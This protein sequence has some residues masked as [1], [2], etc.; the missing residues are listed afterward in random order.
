MPLTGP[1]IQAAIQ[2]AAPDLKGVVWLRL[3]SALG[4]AVAAWG[5][6]PSNL[7]IAGVTSGTAGSGLVNGKLFVTPQPIIVST[8]ASAAGLLGMHAPTI[9]RAVGVGVANGINSSGLYQ[10]TSVGVGVGSDIV[11]GVITNPSA[12]TAQ[13]MA[14]G[15]AAGLRGVHWSDIATAL[16][17]GIASLISSGSRGFGTVTGAGGPTPSAGTSISR[18]V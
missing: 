4:N 1:V 14:V 3:T 17:T 12:L 10:G 7:S 8:A 11:S 5:V 18:M 16:G 6:L 9:A 15:Y 2:A 13:I